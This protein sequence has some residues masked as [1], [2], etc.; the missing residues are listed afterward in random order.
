MTS[1]PYIKESEQSVKPC[2]LCDHTIGKV[3]NA[4]LRNLATYV[5]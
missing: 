5:C 1:N 2:I 3:S 4:S